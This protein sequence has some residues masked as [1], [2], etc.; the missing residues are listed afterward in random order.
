MSKHFENLSN[1]IS[2]FPSLGI[3]SA[4]RILLYLLQNEEIM[5]SFIKSLINL[6]NNTILCKICFAISDNDICEICSNNNR[7]HSKICIVSSITDMW[8]IEKSL[9]YNGLYHVLN[10]TIS[11]IDGVTPFDLGIEKIINRIKFL[12]NL[13]DENEKDHFIKNY[14]HQHIYQKNINKYEII[15]CFSSTIDG[16][17]T[18]QF[19]IDE[20][21]ELKL[22]PK[23]LISIPAK[24]IPLGGG[25]LEY[26]DNAT[27]YAAFSNRNFIK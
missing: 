22:E 20:I 4:R 10:G 16:H 8:A 11:A 14:I 19:I 21:N 9:C 1:L 24:G 3:R 17:A 6:K 18:A 26:L 23:I 27:I 2:K 5:E 15:I 25:D 12:C 7:D 13:S